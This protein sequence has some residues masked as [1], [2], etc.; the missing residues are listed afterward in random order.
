LLLACVLAF[1]S[2]SPAPLTYTPGEGWTYEAVGSTG[3]WQRTR[4]KDQLQVATDA[5]AKKDFK[6]ALKAAERVVKKWPFSDYAP[7]AEFL[8]GRAYEARAM[9][10]KAFKA[11]QKLLE[12]Y[13]KVD[14]YDEIVLRQFEICTRY[15][16]RQWFKL[17]GYIPLYPSMDKT[18]EM[19][20]KVIKNGPYGELAPQ[21][22]MNIGSAREQEKDYPLAVKAYERAADRYNDQKAVAADAVYKAAMAYNKQ[23]KTADYDQSVSALAIS[24]FTDFMT[25]Y[26]DDPRVPAAL[27]I[28]DSLRTEQ[29]NGSFRIAHFYEKRKK[30]NGA[31]VYYNEVLLKKPDSEK[32]KVAR[33]RIEAIKKRILVK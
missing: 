17:W 29:A 8:V 20:E 30:W 32:A 5:Y 24:T 18:A 21:A 16:G 27:K 6:L 2:R 13:P 19:Y 3:K 15:L 1:P 9:D 25:L 10:E 28:I 23:A 14:N 22:Q 12:K 11:Y 26:P 7:K 33:E 31:L 4:A